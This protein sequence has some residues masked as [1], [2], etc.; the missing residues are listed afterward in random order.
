MVRRL[1]TLALLILIVLGAAARV[2]Q[3]TL[4]VLERSPEAHPLGA[5]HVHSSLS[6]DGF[7]SL[8]EIARTAERLGLEFVVVTDHNRQLAGPV[9]LG[10]VTVLSYAELSTPFGHL[11]ALG[12]DQLFDDEE[13][14]RLSVV[15]RIADGHGVAVVTHPADPKRPWDGPAAGLGGFEIA[16]LASSARRRGGPIFLGLLPTLFAYPLNPDLAL[17]QIYDRDHRAL[18]RWD[19]ESRPDVIGLC[20]GD[21]HGRPLPLADNLRGFTLVLEAALPAD[22]ESRPQAILDLLHRSRFHCVAALFGMD[23][24]FELAATSGPE[25]VG[26][27]GD[28][29]TTSQIDALQVTSPK[30]STVQPTLVL[31]RNGEEVVRSQ[32]SSLRYAAPTP[33]TYRVEVRLPIP[34]ILFGERPV[35]VIYSNRIRVELAP[36]PPPPPAPEPAIEASP[37]PAPEPTPEP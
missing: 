22:T 3:R 9:Q 30:S 13:R 6:H 16:N 36:D 28:S 21:A 11:V 25:V 17:A 12:S 10:R 34:G 37:E 31:L 20:G 2:R 24:E 5:F 18:E 35:P 8:E 26:R 32:Q 29:V 1:S 23:P 15:Q 4:P 7:L 33:G 27:P 19:G 14:A